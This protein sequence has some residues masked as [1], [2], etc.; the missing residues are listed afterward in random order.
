MH[1]AYPLPWWLWLVLVSALGALGFIEYRRPL[2]PL[3]AFQ[4]SVLVACRTAALAA[5]VLFLL[6]PIVLLPPTSAR[7]AIVPVLVDVSQSMRLPDAD[8]QARLARA[9]TI[10]R[11]QLLP[12]L[13]RQFRPEIYSVGERLASAGVDDLKIEARRTDLAGALAAIRDR[14]RGQRVAGIV[15]LSDGGD[16][17]HQAGDAA[18]AA[19]GPPVFAIGIGSPDGIRDREVLGITAGDPR[20]DQSSVDLHVSAISFGFGRVPFQLRV[21]ANG[22]VLETRRIVPPADGSP[23]EETFTVLPDLV[24]PTVYTAEIPADVTESV[25]ENNVRSVLVSPAG[26]KRRVLVIEGAP[27]FEHSFLK[28]AL[29]RDASLDVDSVVRKGK[30]ADGQDTFFV[31]A[32]AGRAAA[33]LTGFAA[34]RDDLFAYDAVIFANVD[35]DYLTRAQLT[36]AADFVSERGGGLLVLGG[37]SFNAR[38]GVLGTPLEDA[39]PV[40]LNDRRIGVVRAST[41]STRLE[42]ADSRASLGARDTTT[43]NKVVVTPEGENHPVMRIAGSREE[44]LKQWAAM[45]ALAASAPL[46]GPRPGATVLAVTQASGGAVSPVI[47]VQQYGQG[48]S[49]VFAG[50]A[51]WRWKMMVGSADRSHEFFWRQAVRWLSRPS[52][53]PVAV[54]VP[55][56]SEPGD[57]VAVEIDARDGSF[58]PVADADVTAAITAP[59]GE[60]RPLPLRHAASN[61]RFGGAVQ[62]DDPGLYRVRVAARKGSAPLGSA[63]RWFYVGGSNREFTDPRLNEGFLRRVARASGGRYVGGSEASRVVAWLQS[64]VPQNAAPEQRDLW[65]APWTF[66]LVAVLLSA[67][68]ILRRRWGLR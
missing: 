3:S 5:I 47:A 49:M 60:E 61:G 57:S 53:D 13:S 27:G 18:A 66:A 20:L 64:T 42:A 26:R 67:E 31:Q 63:D 17:G 56:T 6:R 23:V 10:L 9:T 14:S 68:W 16:T 30:N 45:P 43:H 48:R 39:L 37:R 4:R 50:E 51:S 12:V 2:V 28:R 11:T 38:G 46:G 55:E 1:F 33:L 52:P 19:A 54:V 34:R 41:T 59:G 24:N 21:L 25:T 44:S 15:L 32:G 22:R 58:A 40:E 62:A 29:A 36:M 7:E 65:H 8:G 35:A